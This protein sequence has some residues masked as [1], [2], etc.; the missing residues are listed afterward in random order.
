MFFKYEDIDRSASHFS[1]AWLNCYT[2]VKVSNVA[3]PHLAQP[4][5][6]TQR[7]SPGELSR[8]HTVVV[9]V[10]AACHSFLFI[11]LFLFVNP[12]ELL[13]TR[14]SLRWEWA[15][16]DHFRDRPK[17]HTKLPVQSRGVFLLLGSLCLCIWNL[18][19]LCA[20]DPVR[21]CCG[22]GRGRQCV[23]EWDGSHMLAVWT[24]SPN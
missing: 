22:L 5:L 3:M 14:G 16:L 23:S 15:A 4:D 8:N 2:S 12:G 17:N 20:G 1:N 18:I 9:F 24:Y 13:L 10:I 11:P 6:I 21:V 19:P 7:F